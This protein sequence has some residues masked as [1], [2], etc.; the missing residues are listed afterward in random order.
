[1]GLVVGDL[2]TTERT[3]IG[4]TESPST[5]QLVTAG[6]NI[7][8]YFHISFTTSRLLRLAIQF[9][10]RAPQGDKALFFGF[11][12]SAIDLSEEQKRVALMDPEFVKFITYA[13]P[14]GEQAV[15]NVMRERRR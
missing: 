13:D 4:G 11:L 14:T 9:K 10:R 7:V 5:D 15:N 3:R 1:V 8:D 2:T 12:A 6:R